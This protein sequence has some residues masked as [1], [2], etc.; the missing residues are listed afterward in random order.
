MDK[1]VIRM[2]GEQLKQ[3]FPVYDDLPFPI[4]KALKAL[5][6]AELRAD[7]SLPTRQPNKLQPKDLKARG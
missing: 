3:K 1:F 7:G 5:A 4:R 2:A 6:E